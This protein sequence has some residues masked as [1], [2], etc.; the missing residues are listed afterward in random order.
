MKSGDLDLLR[1]L[2]P[3]TLSPDGQSA[4]VA[5]TRPDQG[6]DAYVGQLWQVP[7]DGSAPPRRLARGFADTAPRF[8]PDG[9][10]L[11]FLRASPQGRPPAAPGPG[12][13]R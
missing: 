4:V 12:P 11:A 1:T 6:A 5:V 3:H 9:H 13:R 10:L 2:S 8:S 7:M